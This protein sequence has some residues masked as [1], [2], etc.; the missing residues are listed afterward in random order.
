[1][2]RGT[3]VGYKVGLGVGPV[4]LDSAAGDIGLFGLIVIAIW[5]LLDGLVKLQLIDIS[6]THID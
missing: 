1:M 2:T 4:S 3:N 6:F 5:K